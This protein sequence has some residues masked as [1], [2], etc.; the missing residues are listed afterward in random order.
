ML[1]SFSLLRRFQQLCDSSPSF[2]NV[3]L[4]SSSDVAYATSNLRT[5]KSAP[6][7]KAGLFHHDHYERS[8]SAVSSRHGHFEL[9]RWFG[10]EGGLSS[11]PYRPSFRHGYKFDL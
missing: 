1:L 8:M 9:S 2:L 5:S 10:G 6:T 11:W 4:W 3:L 7:S